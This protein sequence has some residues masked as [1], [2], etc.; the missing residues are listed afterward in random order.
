MGAAELLDIP[1]T[2]LFSKMKRLSIPSKYVSD[3]D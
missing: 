1:T 2:T 3:N